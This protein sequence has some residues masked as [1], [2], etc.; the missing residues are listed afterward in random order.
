M[1]LK[2][3]EIVENGATVYEAGSIFAGGSSK[4]AD[5]QVVTGEDA[6]D[7]LGK[8]YGLACPPDVEQKLRQGSLG[9]R[10]ERDVYSHW[11]W[12]REQSVIC[13]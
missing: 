9:V 13:L 3:G 2:L 1:F 4:A 11:R 6:V 5:H 12:S 7:M 8:A 10:V